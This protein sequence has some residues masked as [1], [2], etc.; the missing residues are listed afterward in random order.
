MLDF[1]KRIF[2]RDVLPYG[3]RVRKNAQLE[4]EARA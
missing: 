2:D 1:L 3:T 4:Q